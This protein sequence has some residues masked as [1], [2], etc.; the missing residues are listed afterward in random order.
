[1]SNLKS[2]YSLMKEN[3]IKA[4]KAESSSS[5]RCIRDQRSLVVG[6]LESMTEGLNNIS[7]AITKGEWDKLSDLCD[8]F[9]KVS[10]VAATRIL[11]IKAMSQYVDDK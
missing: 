8:A 6:D 2:R 10:D 4:K 5:K 3:W 1:M 11:K 9:L 7:D